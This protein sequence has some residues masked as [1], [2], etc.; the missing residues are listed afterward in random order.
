MHRN[1]MRLLIMYECVKRNKRLKY[2]NIAGK[3][4]LF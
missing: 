1:V 3:S 4:V 2:K